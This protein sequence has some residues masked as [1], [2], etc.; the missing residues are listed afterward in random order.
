MLIFYNDTNN[1]CLEH[2]RG[3]TFFRIYKILSNAWKLHVWARTDILRLYYRDSTWWVASFAV[4]VLIVVSSTCNRSWGKVFEVL[5]H[6][7]WWYDAASN[8]A[9][10]P[11]KLWSTIEASSSAML[12]AIGIKTI[13]IAYIMIEIVLLACLPNTDITA[14]IFVIN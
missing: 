8:S 14:L 1:F 5:I 13:L 7:T 3:V 10:A 9:K 12:V 4:S 2:F 6:S 11:C